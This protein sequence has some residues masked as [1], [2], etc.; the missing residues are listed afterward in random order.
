MSTSSVPL[1]K[2]GRPRVR[3]PAKLKPVADARVVEHEGLARWVA[4]NFTGYVGLGIEPA[5]LMQ[6]ARIAIWEALSCHDANA[7]LA[8]ST[9][10]VLVI[11]R[12][13]WRLVRD[14]NVAKR[15]LPADTHELVRRVVDRRQLEP[16]DE[17]EYRD[18]L[19]LFAGALADLA[20]EPSG[21]EWSHQRAV[22]RRRERQRARDAVRR[23][24][25][26][27]IGS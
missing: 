4:K 13:L 14:A 3:F 1:R 9:F 26:R 25:V 11:R 10:A 8:F 2:D 17:V 18:A 5:D 20:A 27:L 23:R 6:E 22:E 24:C 7:G 21:K 12:R 19:N 16:A 15:R